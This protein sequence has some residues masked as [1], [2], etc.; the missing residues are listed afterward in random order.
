MAWVCPVVLYVLCFVLCE[1]HPEMNEP[2]ILW[3]EQGTQEGDVTSLK[4]RQRH[5][6]NQGRS[7]GVFMPCRCSF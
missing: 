3:P 4:F 7:L 2:F 6:E 5:R 1:G